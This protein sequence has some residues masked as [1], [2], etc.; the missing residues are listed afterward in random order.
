MVLIKNQR[1]FWS[2]AKFPILILLIIVNTATKRVETPRPQK[3]VFKLVYFKSDLP[4]KFSQD[5]LNLNEIPGMQELFE[6]ADYYLGKY[7][8]FFIAIKIEESGADKKPS[9]LARKYNNLTGMRFPK[10]RETYAIGATNT[11]YAIYRNWF[12]SML[13]FKIYMEN[14]DKSFARKKGREYQDEMEM[15]N[16]LYSYFN[17]FEKWYNDM[18]FLIPFVQRKYAKSLPDKD[19]SN[20]ILIFDYM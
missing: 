16:H 6:I 1:K 19:N 5:S 13:D 7:A 8:V 10:S 11:N 20:D 12:E 2:I 14:M 9:W 17:G 4:N 3:K 18:R 15:L